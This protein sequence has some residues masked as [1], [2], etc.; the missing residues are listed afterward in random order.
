M[1]HERTVTICFTLTKRRLPIL[2]ATVT[3]GLV[4]V[5]GNRHELRVLEVIGE[6]LALGRGP[7]SGPRLNGRKGML[8]GCLTGSSS[9]QRPALHPTVMRRCCCRH[10]DSHV[11]F[12]AKQ[13]VPRTFHALLNGTT[14]SMSTSLAAVQVAPSYGEYHVPLSAEQSLPWTTSVPSRFSTTSRVSQFPLWMIQWGN[15]SRE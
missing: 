5:V 14:W 9:M 3:F 6:G 15:L 1:G 7:R 8:A 10:T 11:F 12:E 13:K 4:H 2:W